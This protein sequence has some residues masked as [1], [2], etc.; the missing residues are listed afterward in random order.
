M[1]ARRLGVAGLPIVLIAADLDGLYVIIDGT[2]RSVA[3]YR[4]YLT[5]PNTPWRAILA[6]ACEMA[7]S[8]WHIRSPL[9]EASFHALDQA[10]T[11]NWIW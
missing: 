9:V 10:V 6:L 8:I 5:T 7:G 4:H 2:H 1:L 11:Q 3:L